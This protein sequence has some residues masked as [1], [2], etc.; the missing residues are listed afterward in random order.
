M[1]GTALQPPEGGR[2]GPGGVHAH[3]EGGAR[4]WI[5]FLQETVT[6]GNRSGEF[7]DPMESPVRSLPAEKGEGEGGTGRSCSGHSR[8]PGTGPWRPSPVPGPS[9]PHGAFPPTRSLSAMLGRWRERPAAVPLAA[10]WPGSGSMGGGGASVTLG[11]VCSPGDPPGLGPTCQLLS[12]IDRR[13]ST[14][15]R[16]GTSQPCCSTCW[17]TTSSCRGAGALRTHV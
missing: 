14:P 5:A 17:C 8:R 2:R 12:R 4:L 15:T 10:G 1:S 6:S 16:S 7:P 9:S 3:A 11:K 13:G